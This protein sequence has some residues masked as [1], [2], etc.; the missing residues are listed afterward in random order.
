M[1]DFTLKRFL[2]FGN[3]PMSSVSHGLSF[4]CVDGILAEMAAVVIVM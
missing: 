1:L 3:L 2:I 4:L